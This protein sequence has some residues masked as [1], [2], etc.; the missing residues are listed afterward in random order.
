MADRRTESADRDGDIHA[1][2]CVFLLDQY[3]FVPQCR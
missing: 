2:T 1:I 3:R